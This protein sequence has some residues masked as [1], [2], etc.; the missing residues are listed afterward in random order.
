MRCTSGA[1]RTLRL[2]WTTLAAPGPRRWR[3]AGVSGAVGIVALVALAVGV[4]AGVVLPSPAGANGLHS[5]AFHYGLPCDGALARWE[6]HWVDRVPIPRGDG[7]EI[8]FADGDAVYAASVQGTQLWRPIREDDAF[9]IGV[10]GRRSRYG[11]ED[12]VSFDVSRADGALVYAACWSYQPD[13]SDPEI[14]GCTGVPQVRASEDECV[15]NPPL[16][17]VRLAYPGGDV[18]F[19]I[20]DDLHE[21]TVVRP[22]EGT[23]TR[24]AL[25]KFPTWSPD[26]QRIAFVSTYWHTVKP[27]GG[28]PPSRVTR[29]DSVERVQITSRVQ[30]MAADGTDQRSIELPLDWFAGYPPRWSPDGTRLAFLAYEYERQGGATFA[31]YTVR[32][33]GTGLERLAAAARSNPAWSPDGTR[34]AFVQAI[35]NQLHLS[36]MA[37][38]GT[39]VRQITAAPI[40]ALPSEFRWGWTLAWSPDGSRLLYGCADRVCVVGL[41]GQPVGAVGGLPAWAADGR[42][43]VLYNP[44][45]GDRDDVVLSSSAPDGSDW[46]VLVRE[47]ARAGLVAEHAENYWFPGPVATRAACGAGVVV[48][49]PAQHTGLV[50]DCEALVAVRAELFGRAGTNWTTNTPLAAWEGVVVGGTPA[51]VRALLLRDGAIA[52]FDHGGRLPAGIAELA[53]LER[54]ELSKNGLTGSIP[55]EWGAL[56]RLRWLDLSG[57]KLTGAIPVALGQLGNLERLR[58][59]DN[60]LSGAIPPKLGEL[61]TLEQLWLVNNRLTGAIPRE[62]GQLQGLERLGLGN[63]QLTGV[64]PVELG[65]LGNLESLGLENNQLTGEIPAELG[66]LGNLEFLG[67]RDN[68]LTGEIPAELGR[69]RKLRWLYLNNN[70][71]TGA[72]PVALRRLASLWYLELENNQL[73]GCIPAGL[74]RLGQDELA[75]LGLP[76][77]AGAGGVL[78]SHPAVCRAGVVVPAPAQHPGLVADCETLV[79]LRAE[80]LGRAV[81]NWTTNTPLVE[82]EGV[83]VEGSPARVRELV[84]TDG[85][86]NYGGRLPPA[87]A[88]LAYLERLALSKNGLTGPIP[89]AW[90]A[91]VWLRW[92]DLSENHLTGAIPPELGQLRHLE[93]LLLDDNQL[94]GGIPAELGQFRHLEWLVLDDNQLTGTIPAELGQLPHLERLYLN[95]N[96]LT[97]AIPAELGQLQRLEWLGL[98]INQLTGMIPPELGQMQR[99]EGLALA[100]NQLTGV[101]PAELGQLQRLEVLGLGNNQLTGVIPAEF[102][103]LERLERL[104][105][106]NNQLTGAIPAEF[107]QLL[108]LGL[109]GNQFTGCIPVGLRNVG[110]NDL[111]ELYLLDCEAGT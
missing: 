33:D 95:N 60:D 40:G 107:G 34:L 105:L 87:I 62:L 65:H 103:Q 20:G 12:I 74:R 70:H 90:G 57:N 8:V 41:E 67:L 77:C 63:N 71:L 5:N 108:K 109:A 51:R 13:G 83:V 36:T 42:R 56:S 45:H 85:T 15:K 61:M 96:Q 9:Y 81:P 46:W 101:I 48:P 52:R 68:Q 69:L 72:I 94:T 23:A 35:G 64:I 98:E 104:Y 27:A 111:E 86:F 49:A 24:L 6:D 39:D 58:L 79:V 106:N 2:P 29:V 3:R 82:W 17:E 89:A 78:V 102:G 84:L 110:E 88:N 47:D 16:R 91:L 54:L 30:I 44:A 32:A 38:D 59:N 4:V 25:G 37:V 43:I 14:A 73:T 100:Y 11:L 53:F 75:G 80:L 28:D 76:D 50:A 10:D 93:G 31:I 92:L 99:L 19:D 7:R 26:G 55:T 18:L 97:G 1:R 22:D 21:I 66:H